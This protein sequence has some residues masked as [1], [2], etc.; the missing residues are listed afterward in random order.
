M[1]REEGVVPVTR[2]EDENKTQKKES[3]QLGRE[4]AR[5]QP[6]VRRDEWWE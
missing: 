1:A 2:L 3:E 5:V 6:T 4:L